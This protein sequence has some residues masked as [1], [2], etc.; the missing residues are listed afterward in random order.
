MK[1]LAAAALVAAC[2][3]GCAGYRLGEAKPY[4]LRNVKNIAVK[5]FT[6]NTYT[7]RVEVLVTNTVIK[8]LQQDGTFRI[9]TED[10]ADAILDGV[11]SGIGRGPAR[12]VRGNVLASAEFNLGVSVGYTLRTKD[13]AAVAGPASISGG[14]S[15]FVGNDVT[16]DERQALPLAVEDLAVRLVSQLSEGW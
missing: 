15:F 8:Q 10:K 12:A 3:T 7:P 4:A 2:L 16:Q 14:T 1:R 9:T 6:N 11:V 5:T 13:G